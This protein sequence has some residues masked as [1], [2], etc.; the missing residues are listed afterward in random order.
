MRSER[1][2]ALVSGVLALA[3]YLTGCTS[4]ICGRNSDCAAGRVCTTA[5]TCGVPADAA[6]DDLSDGGPSSTAEA[7]LERDDAGVVPDPDQ[8]A[9]S[10]AGSVAAQSPI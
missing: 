6:G 7:G 8:R 10:R 3:L 9:G 4:A 1:C 2:S 5:G